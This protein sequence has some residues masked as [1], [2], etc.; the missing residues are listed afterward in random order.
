MNKIMIIPVIL[1]I[2]AGCAKSEPINTSE[3]DSAPVANVPGNPGPDNP[4]SEID[5]Y[6][7]LKDELALNI[8]LMETS[9]DPWNYAGELIGVFEEMLSYRQSLDDF[10]G[11]MYLS[12]GGGLSAGRIDVLPVFSHGEMS[13]R[14]VK[15]FVNTIANEKMYIQIYNDES[16]KSQWIYEYQNEGGIEGE[17][18]YCEFVHDLDKTLLIIIHEESGIES[19]NSYFLVNYEIDGFELSNYNALYRELKDDTWT[20]SENTYYHAGLKRTEINPVISRQPPHDRKYEFEYNT[21]II[22]LNNHSNDEISV[23]LYRGFWDV[24]TTSPNILARINAY[25]DAL[26]VVNAWLDEHHYLASYTTHE[27]DFHP[28]YDIPPPRF[29]LLGTDYYKFTM[30]YQRDREPVYSHSILVPAD[31]GEL[32]SYYSENSLEKSTQFGTGTV[33]ID[34][35]DNWLAGGH[36]QYAPA[37]LTA[38]EA[39]EIYNSWMKNRFGENT[40]FSGF[41]LNRQSYGKYVV[42]GEQ[43][44]FFPTEDHT[45]FWYNIL[46]NMVTGEMFF[47]AMHDGM[48]W[49]EDIMTLDDWF[50]T[51]AVSMFR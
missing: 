15:L 21:F 6:L 24:S 19:N 40:D 10:N 27:Y 48:F 51:I 26:A 35:M 2:L 8:T 16:I 7:S 20:V 5:V 32:L 46:V 41:S 42:F 36:T 25:Y 49:A 29:S 22:S 14:V 9:L 12:N 17:I 39:V 18:L 50:D 23:Y 45:T 47:V 37:L 33:T 38:E 3:S 31:S 34:L 11:S 44:Y 1:L 30:S 4:G 28:P 13:Y 43:Y